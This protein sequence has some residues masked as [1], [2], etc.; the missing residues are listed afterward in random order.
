MKLG[1]GLNG[2]TDIA[3]GGFVAVLLDEIIGNACECTN[4]KRVFTMTAYLNVSYKRPI[5]TPAV[6]LLR[7][8]VEKREGRKIWGKGTVEDEQGN[9]LSSGDALFVEVSQKL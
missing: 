9:V 8:W 5:P 3:H 4:E 6:V 1:S 7:G 2:H